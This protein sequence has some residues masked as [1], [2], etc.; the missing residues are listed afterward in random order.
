MMIKS[1]KKKRGLDY[2]QDLALAADPALQHS[3]AVDHAVR[4]L[5]DVFISALHEDLR[6]NS[7]NHHNHDEIRE[8]RAIVKSRSSRWQPPAISKSEANIS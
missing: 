6:H 7:E 3:G 5:R 8:P 2:L 1:E 4:L